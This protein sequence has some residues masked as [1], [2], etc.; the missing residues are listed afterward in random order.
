MRTLIT[1]VNGFVGGHLAAHLLDRGDAVSGI[2]RAEPAASTT[3]LVS[4]GLDYHRCAPDDANALRGEL[5]RTGAEAVVHLAGMRTATSPAQVYQANVIG[6]SCLLEAVVAS[7]RPIR[8]VVV[9]SSAMY[10]AATDRAPQTEDAPVHPVTPYGVSKAC[11]DLMAAQVFATTGLP[12]VRA[13]PFNII[14]PGQRGDYFTAVCARQLAEIERGRTPTTVKLGNL[15][16]FRDFLDV[17]DLVRALVAIV[18]RGEAGNAYNVC[19]G[20]GVAVRSVVERMCGL[21]STNVTVESAPPRST[22]TDVPFQAG[23]FAKLHAHTG[24]RPQLSL[25]D[26]LR[27]ILDD[28]RRSVA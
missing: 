8:V 18:E 10:G 9:G 26:T 2:G 23:S 1:G 6:T 3:A 5:E 28:W 19:S 20:T 7:G 22:T 17:R 15:D 4:R 13:R 12:I 16:A 11:A 21:A 27:D 14:G 24:W 25:D